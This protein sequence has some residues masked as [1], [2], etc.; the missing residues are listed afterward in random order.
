LKGRRKGDREMGHLKGKL[1]L[2]MLIVL[3]LDFSFLSFSNINQSS[4]QSV[5]LIYVDPP[6]IDDPSIGA[7]DTFT[8]NINIANAENLYGWQIQM[9]FSP[10]VVNTTTASIHQGSFLSDFGLTTFLP[11]VDNAN[12]TLIVYCGFSPPYPTEGGAWGDGGLASI[13]F[14]A[15]TANGA[16]L[17]QF[18]E[19]TKL[20]TLVSGV[21]VDILNFETADGGFDNRPIGQNALPI[22]SFSVQP[23]AEDRGVVNFNASASYDPDTWLMSY[24]WDY[25]DGSSDIYIRGANLTAFTSHNYTQNGVYPVTLTAKDYDNATATD[26]RTLTDLYDVAIVEVRSFQVA[27]MPGTPVSIDVTA[28]NNGDFLETFNV[29]VYSNQDPIGKQTVT[30]LT[31][32]TQTVLHFTWDTAG[33]SLGNY[34]L[35]ANATTVLGETNTANN[36]YI[37]GQVTIALSNIINFP[38]TIGGQTF[39]VQVNSTSSLGD[40]VFRQAEKKISIEASGDTGTGA[41]CNITIPM[42]LLNS[43]SPSAWVVNFDGDPWIYTATQNGTHYFIFLEYTHS[44]HTIEIIG[45]TVATPPIA[46]FTPSKTTALAGE[47]I[48]FDASASTDPDGTIQSWTWNFDDGEIGNGEAVHHSFTSFGS[49]DVTLT[50]K[51]D[52]DLTNST[53]VTITIIDYPIANFTYTPKPPIA[54]Q[55]VTFDASAS[56]PKGGS[57]TSY[58]W[59]LGDGKTNTSAVVMHKYVATGTFTVNLTVTDSEQL[60]NSVTATITVIGYPTANFTFTPQEP[61]VNQTVNFNAST[62]QPNGGTIT[63]YTWKFGD[64]QNST[65]AST[66]HSYLQEGTYRVELTVTDSEQLTDTTNILILVKLQPE[67]SLSISAAPTILTLG[68]TTTITGTLNPALEDITVTMNYKLETATTW[69][70]LDNEITNANGQYSCN[71]TPTSTGTYEVK[72]YWEGNPTAQPCESQVELITVFEAEEQPIQQESNA[73]L[74]Y[75]AAAIAI[76]LVASI[77]IYF[78]KIRR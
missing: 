30:N 58:L 57:I 44:T 34:V 42:N 70:V 25:G 41:F 75:A 36:E 43:S 56:Q 18:I 21:V 10:E 78:L 61:F 19:R 2:A 74:L 40:F 60:S 27:V 63:N 55:A 4:A 62:S 53:S 73:M 23:L 77:A 59:K 64:G 28:A 17:L 45:E 12:G 7:G 67:S 9:S 26:S 37:D 20:K 69:S 65:G 68:Q 6:M 46:Q 35:K 31:P 16:T 32:K 48:S 38:V 13:T 3:I 1:L 29:S 11:E 76:I 71:W 47:S 15:K 50:V 5:P 24:H 8:I 52:E 39:T 66:S 22:A 51:D 54:D 33:T 49:Y 72:A 14:K